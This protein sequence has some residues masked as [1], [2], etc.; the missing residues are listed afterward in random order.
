M[1]VVH[2]LL[3]TT[4]TILRPLGPAARE[5]GWKVENLDGDHLEYVLLCR[6][7]TP[8]PVWRSIVAPQPTGGGGFLTP[9]TKTDHLADCYRTTHRL[10]RIGGKTASAGAAADDDG[11]VFFYFVTPKTPSPIFAQERK[12]RTIYHLMLSCVCMCV[13][14]YLCDF[15]ATT[16][17]QRW[18]ECI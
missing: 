12:E 14:V 7:V 13:C 15:S 17:Q 1:D 4:P 2:P 10:T 11:K 5:G 16:W 3:T 9:H 8:R 6:L 18:G